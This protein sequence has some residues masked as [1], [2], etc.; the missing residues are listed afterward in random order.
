MPAR[1]YASSNDARK[2]HS[3]GKKPEREIITKAEGTTSTTVSTPIKCE[4]T[5][6]TK[7]IENKPHPHETTD[8]DM[9]KRLPCADKES[10]GDGIGSK[11]T[12]IHQ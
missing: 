6:K 8:Y 1:L 11:I 10:N 4:A 3:E 12:Q 5:G 7:T 9:E 2:T